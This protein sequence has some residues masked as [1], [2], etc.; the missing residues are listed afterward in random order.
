MES[1]LSKQSKSIINQIKRT[2]SEFTED[3][4]KILAEVKANSHYSFQKIKWISINLTKITK[5]DH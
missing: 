4:H 5:L 1:T 2:T 3:M